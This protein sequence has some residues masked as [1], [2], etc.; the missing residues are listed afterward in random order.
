MRLYKK[1]NFTLESDLA[2]TT[3]ETRVMQKL[4][5]VKE[6]LPQM[7]KEFRRCDPRNHVEGKTFIR[8]TNLLQ[9]QMIFTWNSILCQIIAF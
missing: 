6:I 1:G 9:V 2:R 5:E 3:F 7:S 8:M 4:L